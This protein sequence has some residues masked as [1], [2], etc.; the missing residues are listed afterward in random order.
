M[1]FFKRFLIVPYVLIMCNIYLCNIFCLSMATAV[2]PTRLN[3]TL[4]YVVR[5]VQI[6]HVSPSLCCFVSSILIIPIRGGADTALKAGRSRV[7]FPMVSWKF[8]IY[9]ILP[10]VLWPWGRLSL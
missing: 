8:F 6:S 7:R 4:N 10:A 2:A 3:A 5:L 9:L 1:V